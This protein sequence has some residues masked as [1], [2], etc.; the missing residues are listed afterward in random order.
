MTSPTPCRDR[1]LAARAAVDALDSS[2][3]GD[4]PGEDEAAYEAAVAEL[5]SAIEAYL[6]S[7]EP[8]VQEVQS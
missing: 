3:A 6:A 1:Y 8:S 7:D 4:S 5:A 2:I